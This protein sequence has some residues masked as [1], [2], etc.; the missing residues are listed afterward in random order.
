MALSPTMENAV[1]RL[2]KAAGDY[3]WSSDQGSAARAERDKREL[4]AAE[5]ALRLAITRA[6]GR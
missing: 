6:E 2:I 5:A 4:D 1:R 3:G